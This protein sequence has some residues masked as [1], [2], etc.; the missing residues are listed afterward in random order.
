MKDNAD[1]Y[2]K[3]YL[4]QSRKQGIETSGLE[5]EEGLTER[6]KQNTRSDTCRVHKLIVVDAITIILGCI[7]G[8]E[9]LSII[10]LSTPPPASMIPKAMLSDFMLSKYGDPPFER[11]V[12]LWAI[13]YAGVLA[14]VGKR[15]RNA[16]KPTTGKR[17]RAINSFCILGL[18][19]GAIFQTIANDHVARGMGSYYDAGILPYAVAAP[20][21]LAASLMLLTVQFN[22]AVMLSYY[23]YNLSHWRIAKILFPGFG[24]IIVGL[25]FTLSVNATL[26]Y[27]LL[28]MGAI[29]VGPILQYVLNTAK[30][31]SHVLIQNN[32]IHVFWDEKTLASIKNAELRERLIKLRSENQQL[33]D[34]R[35]DDER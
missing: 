14:N 15:L 12:I 25:Y 1:A 29:M 9:L 22:I 19:L 8:I 10:M 16:P 5:I 23:F 18:L 34:A 31:V 11:V 4:K 21:F 7:L 2:E 6:A 27:V 33:N 35:V 17:D 26:G 20:L 28:S 3:D 24:F 13:A 30:T 32:R